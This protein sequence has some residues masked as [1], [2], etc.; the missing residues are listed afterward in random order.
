MNFGPL[1]E[2][3]TLNPKTRVFG[4]SSAVVVGLP[5]CASAV[6]GGWWVVVGGE[7]VGCVCWWWRWWVVVIER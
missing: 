6:G 5:A 2:P 4:F 1:P 3:K 7:V